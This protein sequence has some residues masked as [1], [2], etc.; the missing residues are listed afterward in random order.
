MCLQLE[1]PQCNSGMYEMSFPCFQ[2]DINTFAQVM[3]NSFQMESIGP[4]SLLPNL[5]ESSYQIV[6]TDTTA[7]N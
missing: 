6:R 5:G 3:W 4:N 2:N 1:T 7:T